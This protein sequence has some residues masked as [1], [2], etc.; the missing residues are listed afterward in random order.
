MIGQTSV[1][2]Q[3]SPNRPHFSPENIPPSLVP[4]RLWVVWGGVAADARGVPKFDKAPR[5]PKGEHRP[6]GSDAGEWFT[7]GDCLAAL[8]ACPERIFGLGRMMNAAED[9]IIGVDLDH[10]LE[11]E[12]GREY[13]DELLR[14]MPHAY[15]ERSPSG[16]GVRIF[17]HA[18]G[19]A[20]EIQAGGRECLTRRDWP[21]PGC[22]IE[23]YAYARGKRYLTITGDSIHRGDLAADSSAAVRDL[24]AEFATPRSRTSPTSGTS[25]AA[26][27]AELEPADVARA[28][29]PLLGDARAAEYH[30]WIKIGL[31]CKGAGLG[32]EDWI[33]F[34]KRCPPEFNLTECAKKWATFKPTRANV[35]WL[36]AKAVEDAGEDRVREILRELHRHQPRGP[37]WKLAP[38]DRRKFHAEDRAAS[39][40]ARRADREQAR[41]KLADEI[42]HTEITCLRE[43]IEEHRDR[44]RWIDAREKWIEW[45]EGWWRFDAE[46]R[47]SELARSTV[48][49]SFPASMHRLGVANA[50][51]RDAQA[52]MRFGFGELD[53]EREI[54]GVGPRGA[55]R[56]VDLASGQMRPATPEDLVLRST[57]I[58][59]GG[60]A[61]TWRRCLREWTCDDADLARY[62][63]LVAGYC[64]TGSVALHE[65]YVLHGDGGDGK[66]K[67][68]EWIAR[69]MGPYAGGVNVSA[70]LASENEAHPTS[71][72]K[73][74]GLRLA[75]SSELPKG[76]EWNESRMKQL[77]G[78]DTITAR[79]MGMNEFDFPPTHKFILATNT[80]PRIR[81]GG[82]SWDR[83][84][85]VIPFRAQ[86]SGTSADRALDAKL[87]PELP[88]ILAWMLEG[89]RDVLE[90]IRR[91]AAPPMPEAVRLANGEYLASEDWFGQFIED[92]FEIDAA[93]PGWW[94]STEEIIESFNAWRVAAGMSTRL[95]LNA[96]ALAHELRR[97]KLDRKQATSGERKQGWTGIRPRRDSSPVPV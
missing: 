17:A 93:E 68:L 19:A 76:S 21:G 59:S 91:G 24:V 50:L 88:G 56:I 18:P 89:A 13:V 71:R 73:L 85:R 22:S 32:L 86:F 54:I 26:P 29:L 16:S 20:A 46:G 72:A 74:A 77:T 92:R 36:R 64:L 4:G 78:G 43:F 96:R 81:E 39:L 63:Q 5:S 2:S 38:E 12:R 58:E 44:W 42:R 57:G 67:F 6:I 41:Q 94:C 75:Y 48:E 61:P 95:E 62:L 80:L 45:R 9:G 34:S 53:V 82:P 15:F 37:G 25:P 55:E 69:A 83:R 8:N 66:T 90:F 14:R 47:I 52:S 51:V 97:R 35:S 49:R 70:L 33:G 11:H 65:F 40:D 23:F 79:F 10:V 1:P 28:M 84:I 3:V 60:D 7:F 27:S 31:A 87:A 30:E